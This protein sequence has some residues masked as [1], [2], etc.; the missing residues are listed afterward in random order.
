MIAL[1]WLA[2][3]ALGWLAF[4]LGQALYS[5]R[6]GA[7]FALLLLTRPLLVLETGQAVIDVPFLALVVAAMLAEARRPRSGWTVP[8]LLFAAGLLAGGLAARPRVGGVGGVR[9]AECWRWRPPRWPRPC[10][11]WRS[12]S[13]RR[14]TRCTRCTGPRSWPAALATT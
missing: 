14:E 6:I 5:A 9:A 10:C 7:L 3:G 1:S 13:R 4:R 8:I 11:G 12:I 2:L